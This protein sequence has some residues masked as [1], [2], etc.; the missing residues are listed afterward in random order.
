MLFLLFSL[1]FLGGGNTPLIDH[2]DTII[3]NVKTEVQSDERRAQAVDILKDVEKDTKDFK[4]R[5]NDRAKDLGRLNET[6]D[7]DTAAAD[8]IWDVMFND[9]ESYHMQI[10]SRRQ[11][12]K[13]VMNQ[14]EWGRVF[15]PDAVD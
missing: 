4:K 7:F 13:S 3:D 10:L 2:I 15:V 11:E 1:L 6:P 5:Q 14:N 9:L 12:L 8:A